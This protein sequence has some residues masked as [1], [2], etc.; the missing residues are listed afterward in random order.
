MK[1]YLARHG[2][3]QDNI[4]GIL[5]GH[6]DMPL[7]DLGIEQANALAKEIKEAGLNFEAIYCSPLQRAK[8]TAEIIASTIG[9]KEPEVLLELIERNFG[10]LTGL[11]AK[12]IESLCT[13]DIIKTDTITYFLN[14]EGAETFPDLVERGKIIIEKVSN[15]GHGKSVLLVCH[16]DIGK[17]IYTA[18]YKLD[19]KNVLTQFHFGNSEVLLLSKDSHPDDSHVF[20]FL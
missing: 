17:M 19:W 9:V 5:N 10:V 6:R 11:P 2:Q 14:P 16:G 20:S 3:D 4:K 1:I 13:P 8:K 7:T 18:Y 15:H 12:D